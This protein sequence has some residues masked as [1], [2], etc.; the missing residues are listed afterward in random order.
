M[1][2]SDD[3]LLEFLSEYEL[4][5]SP[6]VIEYNLNTRHKSSISYSTV[7][8]RLKLLREAELVEKE[9]EEGGFYA[10]TNRGHAYLKGELDADELEQ[11]DQ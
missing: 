8:R 9:Y 3:T 4:A 5:L 2:D 6:R 11:S 1:T 10:I 7:N